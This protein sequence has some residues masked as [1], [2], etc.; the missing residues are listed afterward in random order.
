MN[1]MKTKNTKNDVFFSV[2]DHRF[3]QRLNVFK[4]IGFLDDTT[5]VNYINKV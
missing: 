2:A 4:T 3:C 1:D 5:E